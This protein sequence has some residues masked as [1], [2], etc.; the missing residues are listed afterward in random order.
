MEMKKSIVGISSLTALL[1]FLYLFYAPV[2]RKL[3]AVKRNLKVMEET[4]NFQSEDIRRLAGLRLGER[5]LSSKEATYLINNLIRKSEFD[6]IN[7][8]TVNIGTP[9]SLRTW[10]R[11]LRILPVKIEMK[12]RYED[13]AEFLKALEKQR[14]ALIMVRNLKI[15][16]DKKTL[17][18]LKEEL[19]LEV[20]LTLK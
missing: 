9:A 10:E 11:T 13:L 7:F 20:Y 6:E 8:I 17:P 19:L 3:S 18:L 2:L 16:R 5:F 1:F 4:L 14:E 12:A 15:V